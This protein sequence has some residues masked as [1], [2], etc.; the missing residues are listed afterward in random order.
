M[1]GEVMTWQLATAIATDF[2]RT[3]GLY[4]VVIS[5]TFVAAQFYHRRVQ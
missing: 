4:G 1:E 3:V 2:G 5:A